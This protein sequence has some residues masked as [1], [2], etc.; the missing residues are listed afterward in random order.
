[1]YISTNTPLNQKVEAVLLRDSIRYSNM[2]PTT[3]ANVVGEITSIL[4]NEQDIIAYAEKDINRAVS[5]HHDAIQLAE[6]STR[7][8]QEIATL[9]EEAN[10]AM[11]SFAESNLNVDVVLK[12]NKLQKKMFN[13]EMQFT[14]LSN[15]L[16][17]VIN[18]DLVEYATRTDKMKTSL[19]GVMS[20]L[21]NT[22]DILDVIDIN[23]NSLID[24]D[25]PESAWDEKFK[26][27]DKLK[28]Q[29]KTCGTMLDDNIKLLQKQHITV[30]AAYDTIQ[31]IIIDIIRINYRVLLAEK[32]EKERLK[33]DA[34]HQACVNLKR[35]I[36]SVVATP[37]RLIVQNPELP[38][39][40]L[41][42]AAIVTVVTLGVAMVEVKVNDASEP[43]TEAIVVGNTYKWVN[44][45]TK[46][47]VNYIVQVVD[48]QPSHQY[49]YKVQ[50]VYPSDNEYFGAT[51]DVDD[52]GCAKLG[53]TFQG[54]N[55]T[56][57]LIINRRG[58]CAVKFNK[59]AELDAAA[60]TEAKTLLTN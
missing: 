39:A 15:M 38:F 52:R 27:L 36:T 45:Y 19:L 35:K 47:K 54:V 4:A 53:Q 7:K 21:D 43:A 2:T 9:I 42:F 55:S 31:H 51:F 32:D 10:E 11:A 24:N 57:E 48:V 33:R 49:K 30:N 20:V 1:M 23:K 60:L 18:K 29:I 58:E 28:T 46:S 44:N 16:S 59:P 25:F 14:A 5:M 22:T 40:M 26:Q 50:L 56:A 13:L 12:N 3:Q 6:Q 34:R 8:S 41:I 17:T 37:W